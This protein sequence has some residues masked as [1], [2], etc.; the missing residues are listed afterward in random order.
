MEIVQFVLLGLGIGA[1][2][3]LLGQGLV[4]IYRG[5][6][7]VNFAQ[8]SFVMVGGYAYY[9]FR[10]ALSWPA[11]PGY[12][13]GPIS[14]P[15]FLPTDSVQPLPGTTLGVDR[16]IILLIGAVLTGTLFAVFRWT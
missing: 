4:L 2:Y 3:S 10:V 6:G 8:G 1:I 11:V 7:I 5:S 14:V 15:S 16:L 13:V 9:E 12:G